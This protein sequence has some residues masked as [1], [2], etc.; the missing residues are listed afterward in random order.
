MS[1][2]ST[3][4]PAID[5]GQSVILVVA[6]LP[7][8]GKVKTRLASCIGADAAL[9]L[10]AAF[11]RDTL[12]LAVRMARR[13]DALPVLAYA[14]ERSPSAGLAGGLPLMEQENGDLGHRQISAHRRLFAAGAATVL[15]IGSDSPTLPES[16]FVAALEALADHDAVVDPASD[17]GYTLLGVTRPVPGLLEGVPWGTS[18]V[19]AILARNAAA[20]GLELAWLPGWYDVDDREG[21]ERLER[22][23]ETAG[24]ARAPDSAA[25][26]AS[27]RESRAS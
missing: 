17:G 12:R 19:Q 14:G 15:T 10:H 26:L 16:H 3:P 2:R 18:G 23:L 21:L 27:W 24:E 5:P 25:A 6:R 4:L 7:E 20:Q 9:D 1:K 11:L 13:L 8:R 22:D